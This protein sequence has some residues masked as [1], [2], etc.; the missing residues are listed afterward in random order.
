MVMRHLRRRNSGM[1]AFF[2]V[3]A[4]LIIFGLVG[5]SLVGIFGF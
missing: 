4:I 1:R 2:M 5:S 3:V